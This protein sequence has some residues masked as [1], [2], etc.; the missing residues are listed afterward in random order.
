MIEVIRHPLAV[1]HVSLGPGVDTDCY[2]AE[3]GEEAA[4][5]HDGDGEG[6]DDQRYVGS[7][8]R[9]AGGRELR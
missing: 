9:L 3:A 1:S 2:A 7:Q 4:E 8:G 5:E 6:G